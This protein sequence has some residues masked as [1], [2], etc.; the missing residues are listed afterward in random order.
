[1]SIQLTGD[2]EVLTNHGFVAVEELSPGTLI[3]TGQGLSKVAYEVV[4]GTLL[5]DGH[6]DVNSS[7]LS[8]AH[9]VA[10]ADYARLKAEILDEL[11][12]QLSTF[13]VASGGGVVH[14]SVHVR[15]RAHRALRTLRSDFY[16]P[17]KRV[18]SWMAERLTPR[19][20]AFWFMDDGYT[21]VRPGRQ[22]LAEIATCG[23]SE[24][25][26]GILVQG[27]ERL[28]LAAKT[29]RGR[30][31][32]DVPTTRALS[33][34]IAPYVPPV[35][36]YKLHP[37]IRVRVPFDPA[38]LGPGTPTVSYDVAE[39]EDITDRQR[40]DATFFCIDVEQTHN[41]VTAGGVVH[42]CR[43]PGNRDPQPDEIEACRDWLDGTIRLVDPKIVATLGNFAARTLLQTTTGITRLRGRT[44]PF[45]GRLLLP[46]FHPSAALR[47]DTTG[48][49]E[50][51]TL[52]GMEEDFQTLSRLLEE[53]RPAPAD[54]A[55]EAAPAPEA[56]VQEAEPDSEQLGLF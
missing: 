48:R 40:T 36:R 38:L 25:D 8:L 1:V 23:F 15:T 30:L 26:L 45:Q 10:Q 18:P 2:H 50:N 7:H 6:L 13:K 21:R 33:E 53:R 47:A 19:M 52:K 54:P 9:G 49:F 44:Y 32:F 14:P 35:M 3:A 29:R 51:R 31:H 24:D 20:L 34:A 22:P 28:G 42:N 16:A 4:C 27:L 11:S 43:P 5:G 39:V 46:T 17:K 56:A 37:D 12:P 55:A 41:F